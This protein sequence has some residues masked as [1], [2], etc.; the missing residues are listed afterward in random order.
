MMTNWPM[1]DLSLFY[2]QPN[3]FGILL[4]DHNAYPGSRGASRVARDHTA[5]R[6]SSNSLLEC[7][8]R[9]QPSFAYCVPWESTRNPGALKPFQISQT[10]NTIS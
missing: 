8:P 4:R 1:V 10:A 7:A 6:V 2:Q 9:D 5:Y 3:D